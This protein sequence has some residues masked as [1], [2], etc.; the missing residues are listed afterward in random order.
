MA[1]LAAVGIGLAASSR[2]EQPSHLAGCP[3]DRPGRRADRGVDQCR[4]A[5]LAGAAHLARGPVVLAR[6]R[7][8]GAGLLLGA[9]FSR[10]SLRARPLRLAEAAAVFLLPYLFTSLF[11]LSSAHLLADLGRAIGIGRWFGWYGEATF[12][13][14]VLLFLVNEIVIV[15]GGWLIDGRWTRSWR[16]RGLLL[17]AA[18]SRA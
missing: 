10:W 3:A 7:R 13:R 14:I 9:A 5:R 8:R 12:G 16:L 6:R 18:C 17:L 4:D 2:L 15:G 1:V 11:L